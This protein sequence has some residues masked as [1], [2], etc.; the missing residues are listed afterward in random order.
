MS[1]TTTATPITTRPVH[2]RPTTA[3]RHRPAL[4]FVRHLAEM[5]VAMGVGMATLYPLWSVATTRAG[6]DPLP[7]E[8]DLLAMATAMAVPMALLMFHRGHRARLVVEMGL[9]MYAGF[10][11]LFPFHWGGTLG[12]MGVMMTGHVLMPLFM[13][14]A[15]LLRR[16]EYAHPHQ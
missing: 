8:V 10:V 15:M 2:G 9:A 1:T 7:I 16:A 14:A 13:I 6:W 5:L 11:V 3:R 12:A 4:T